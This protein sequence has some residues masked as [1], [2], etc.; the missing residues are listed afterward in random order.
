MQHI[1]YRLQMLLRFILIIAAGGFGFR[2]SLDFVGVV[3][4][5][6]I[7]IQPVEVQL[8]ADGFHIPRLRFR[9]QPG[10]LHIGCQLRA[11]AAEKQRV[12]EHAVALDLVIHH[13]AGHIIGVVRPGGVVLPHV[14]HHADLTGELPGAEQLDRLAVTHQQ[15]MDTLA[16]VFFIRKPRGE[17]APGVADIGGDW[18]VEGDP[19]IHILTKAVKEDR[20]VVQIPVDDFPVAEAALHLEGVRQIPV[21]NGGIDPDPGRL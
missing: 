10:F 20:R 3:I 11:V 6:V 12:Q 19:V 7:E 16:G 17:E 5:S 9:R 21:I 14:H 13:G 15:M 18:L 4:E 2:L 1:V 8:L